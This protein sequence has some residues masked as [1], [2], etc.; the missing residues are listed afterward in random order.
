MI[1]FLFQYFHQIIKAKVKIPLKASPFDWLYLVNEL[2][3]VTKINPL[4]RNDTQSETILAY[5]L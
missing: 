1:K 4:F 3:L 2:N 5:N